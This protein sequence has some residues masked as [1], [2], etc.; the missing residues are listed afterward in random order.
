MATSDSQDSGSLRKLNDDLRSSIEQ[1]GHSRVEALV[2]C[3]EDGEDDFKKEALRVKHLWE[4]VF[5]FP[6]TVFLIPSKNSHFAV[7]QSV[8]GK[9]CS[10]QERG[11]SL[12]VLHYGGHG[13]ADDDKHSGQEK[14][15]VWAA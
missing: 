8:A 4:N 1:N 10:V 7:L 5:H 3:W 13:D 14:R 9:L 6:T 11:P 15:S 12:L 2:L